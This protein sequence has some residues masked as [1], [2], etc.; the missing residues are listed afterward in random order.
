MKLYEMVIKIRDEYIEKRGRL[1]PL[2]ALISRG[3]QR[4]QEAAPD[5]R[6]R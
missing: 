6:A 3:A 4:P 5:T 1:R 2:R